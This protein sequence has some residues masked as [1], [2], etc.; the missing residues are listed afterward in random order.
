MYK[1]VSF[2]TRSQFSLIFTQKT[3]FTT[4]WA[5]FSM[6]YILIILNKLAYYL[7]Q[8][9]FDLPL[10]FNLNLALMFLSKRRPPVTKSHV[11][12]KFGY[13]EVKVTHIFAKPPKI[14]YRNLS[15]RKIR[16]K[17]NNLLILLLESK[18]LAWLSCVIC[19]YV[20]L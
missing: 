19:D 12:I 11:T 20:K 4:E 7:L 14:V 18:M 6:I 10:N 3:N 16:Q 2:L 9:L 8:T 5:L 17:Q 13:N 1:N 15:W